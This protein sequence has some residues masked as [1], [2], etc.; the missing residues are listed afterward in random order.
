MWFCAKGFQLVR[1]PTGAGGL[2][3]PKRHQLTKSWD[4][5]SLCP[6]FLYV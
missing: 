3:Q 4:S 1:L 6:R 2:A 5:P